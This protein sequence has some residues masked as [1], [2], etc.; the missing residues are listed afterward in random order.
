MLI[1]RSVGL[2]VFGLTWGGQGDLISRFMMGR[3]GVIMWLIRE[4]KNIHK[5]ALTLPLGFRV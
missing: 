5:V 1:S 2:D 3:T 4:H